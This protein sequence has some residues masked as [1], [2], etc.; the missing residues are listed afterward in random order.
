M[1]NIDN[2]LRPKSLSSFFGQKEIVSQLRAF[3]FSAK[4]RKTVLDHI[5]FYGPPGLGKTTL[6]YIIAN[7]MKGNIVTI[8]ASS[9]DKSSELISI[10]G[11]LNPGDILFI[12]EI[13]RL[14]REFMEILYSAMEDF[15]I[16]ATYKNDENVKALSFF[17]SPFTLIGATTNA[18]TLS[19][20]LRDR[21]SI[22]FKFDYY[23][24]DEIIEIIKENE[25]IFNLNLSEDCYQEIALRSRNTPRY[26]NNLLKRLYDYKVY[27][28]IK[29]FDKNE[30]FNAFNFLK[31]NKYGLT[32]ED[33]EIIK[34]MKEKFIRPTSLEAIAALINDDVNNIKNI[35]EPFLVSKGIIERTK[36]GRKLTK[37]GEVIYQEFYKK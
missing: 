35:N 5:L 6:A 23:K 25:K 3:I 33:I 24:K 26:L 12:D 17:L 2:T 16:H 7:E 18:G 4:S 37:F 31:I 1:S 22:I 30:L 20:P 10:L 34:I 21:F 11:Q 19:I 32:R 36:Q 13:H 8:T 28:K 15:K 29:I 27:K 9:I 14:K